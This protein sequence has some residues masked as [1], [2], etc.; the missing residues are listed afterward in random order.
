MSPFAEAIASLRHTR[1]G[2]PRRDAFTWYAETGRCSIDLVTDQTA[3]YAEIYHTQPWVHAAVNKLMRSV[4][5]LPL[6]TY[7][8]NDAGQRAGRFDG[9]L[10][11]L[12][13]RPFRA[14]TPSYW[15]QH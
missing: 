6:K 14:G 7:N 3:S 9:P 13:H 8:R 12:M 2:S 15:K 1:V 10:V 11:E 4:G 5:M